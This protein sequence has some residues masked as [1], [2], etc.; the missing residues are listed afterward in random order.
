[1]QKGEYKS[2]H[3]LFP[4]FTKLIPTV[5]RTDPLSSLVSH[6][7]LNAVFAVNVTVQLT[8]WFLDGVNEL[9]LLPKG[10]FSLK[11][12]MNIL[13]SQSVKFE[14]HNLK[15]YREPVIVKASAQPA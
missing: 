2:N 13:N 12:L 4:F 1:M 11:E 9:V 10:S 8:V 7:F 3:E 15:E 14:D 5:R 6:G